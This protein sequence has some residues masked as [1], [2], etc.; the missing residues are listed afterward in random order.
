MEC[1]IHRKLFNSFFTEQA[2]VSCLTLTVER[3]N[4][5]HTNSMEV[6]PLWANCTFIQIILAISTC[7]SR[8]TG[9]FVT[10]QLINALFI[11]VITSHSHTVVNLV[12]AVSSSI[13]WPTGIAIVFTELPAEGI[14][15]YQRRCE[16]DSGKSKY[17]LD[18]IGSDIPDSR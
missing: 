3:S 5:I 7:K 15:T 13:S 11:R 1:S 12:R 8:K 17:F 2:C 18:H 4:A 9:T 10:F 6:A 14:L 16:G